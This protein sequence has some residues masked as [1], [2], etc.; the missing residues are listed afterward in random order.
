MKRLFIS[1]LLSLAL[2]AQAGQREVIT[3]TDPANDDFGAGNLVYPE[4]TD[5]SK[6]DLDLRALKISPDGEGYWFEATFANPV[7]DPKNA[8][9]GIGPEPMPINAR[10]GFYTFNIDIYVDTDRTPGSGNTFTL[11]GRKARIDP[12]YAWER[13]IALTPRPEVARSELFD[14]LSRQ[15]PERSRHEAE[16]SIHQAVYFPTDIRVRGKTIGFYVP[17]EFFGTSDAGDW[18]VTALVTGAKPFTAMTIGLLPTRKAPLDEL[19]MGAMQPSQGRPQDTFG[20]EVGAG[21]SPIVDALMPT[22]AQ[23]IAQLGNDEALT[24]MS[25]GP[26]AADENALA[27]RYERGAEG[28]TARRAMPPPSDSAGTGGS[29]LSNTLDGLKGWFRG[30]APSAQGAARGGKPAPIG[31]F[32]D[33]GGNA[34]GVNVPAARSAP[35]PDR[36]RTLQQLY[37]DKLIDEA[38]YR[39]HKQRILGD[40]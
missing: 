7:R 27:R 32:L 8:K 13:V 29:F 16:A 14:V 1:C 9:T 10:R 15:F 39:L 18:A 6:G 34:P 23:Q 19:D 2:G 24:G 35:V 26:R 36:L 22:V 28:V 33:P 20:Y 12:A 4:R 38:E 21:A 30:D 40:L 31:S 5:F 25:W 37:D 11:P 3:L 17:G